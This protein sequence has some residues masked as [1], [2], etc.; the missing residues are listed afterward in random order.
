MISAIH[1]IISKSAPA[2]I[3]PPTGL[4]I[5][6][7]WVLT[8]MEIINGNDFRPLDGDARAYSPSYIPV[9]GVGEIRGKSFVTIFGLDRLENSDPYN[10]LDYAVWRGNGGLVGTWQNNVEKLG[11]YVP[12]GSYER[13]RCDGS[14]VYFEYSIDDTLSWLPIQ[15]PV[16]QLQEKLYPKVSTDPGEYL[17]DVFVSGMVKD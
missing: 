5:L 1:G 17:D 8:R 4:V 12:V 7:D 6:N 2:V 13:V 10:A 9:G 15:A 3:T 11:D 16:P 14:F